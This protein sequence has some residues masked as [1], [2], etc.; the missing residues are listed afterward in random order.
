[1]SQHWFGKRGPKNFKEKAA[2]IILCLFGLLVLALFL[3]YFAILL[4]FLFKFFLLIII[5]ALFMAFFKELIPVF[6]IISPIII[7]ICLIGLLF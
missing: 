4:G 3:Y 5:C 2:T 6:I 7:L 1:M